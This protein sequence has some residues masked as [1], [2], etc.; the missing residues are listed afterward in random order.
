MSVFL[1]VIACLIPKQHTESLENENQ[2][3]PPL[4]QGGR[5][6]MRNLIELNYISTQWI[7]ALDSTLNSG[8]KNKK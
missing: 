3:S 2:G 8:L 4:S 5:Q 1:Y 7:Y 6:V